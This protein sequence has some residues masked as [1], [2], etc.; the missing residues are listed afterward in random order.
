MRTKASS[1][2]APRPLTTSLARSPTLGSRRAS[3]SPK[4]TWSAGVRWAATTTVRRCAKRAPVRGSGGGAPVRPVLRGG[5]KGRGFEGGAASPRQSPVFNTGYA[6]LA[7]SGKPALALLWS[8]QPP[9][10][11]GV[12]VGDREGG[13]RQ[14]E[15]SFPSLPNPNLRFFRL[16]WVPQKHAGSVW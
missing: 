2:R 15:Q 1:H 16:I 14:C 13:S 10:T 12:Y 8:C 3:A 11:I 6:G 9:R 4:A 7:S 5:A